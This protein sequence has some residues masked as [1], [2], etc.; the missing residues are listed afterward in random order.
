MAPWYNQ[1][2]KEEFILFRCLIYYL[3]CIEYLSFEIFNW[4]L[5][6]LIT[7]KPSLI[8]P[9][10]N[11]LGTHVPKKRAVLQERTTQV[12][13]RAGSTGWPTT[14]SVR[15]WSDGSASA[16]VSST[17]PGGRFYPSPHRSRTRAA[18]WVAFAGRTASWTNLQAQSLLASTWVDRRRV[19]TLSPFHQ[20]NFLGFFLLF[21][22]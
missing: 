22:F 3:L 21:P 6:L 15:S 14:R 5:L 8:R 10:L 2:Q 4:Y 20:F 9:W 7:Q 1:W 18:S 13:A 17:P 19:K 16:R 12:A 11:F